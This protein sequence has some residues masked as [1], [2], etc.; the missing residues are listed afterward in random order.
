[1]KNFYIRLIVW[2]LRSTWASIWKYNLTNCY[3]IEWNHNTVYFKKEFIW[4]TCSL[5]NMSLHVILQMKQFNYSKRNLIIILRYGNVN[6]P[7]IPR[8]LTLFDYFFRPPSIVR[9]LKKLRN[10]SWTK[11]WNRIIREI[12]PQLCKNTIENVYK[13]VEIYGEITFFCWLKIKKP[14]T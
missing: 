4:M 3:K 8:D 9:R 13:Q 14:R 11:E 10:N 12:E 2:Y 1:M 6:W 7:P 5:K